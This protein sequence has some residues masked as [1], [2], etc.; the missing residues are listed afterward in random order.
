MK[1]IPLSE[2][3]IGDH[4]SSKNQQTAFSYSYPMGEAL[5]L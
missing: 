2:V 3:D 1:T 5:T 4:I